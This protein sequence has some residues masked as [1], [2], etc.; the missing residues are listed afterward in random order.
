MP[1]ARWKALECLLGEDV[2]RRAQIRKRLVDV[3]DAFGL[4]RER[5]FVPE[6]RSECCKRRSRVNRFEV[7]VEA[8]CFEGGGIVVS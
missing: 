2:R 5:F 8:G 6:F 3:Y 7:A 4:P 1:K